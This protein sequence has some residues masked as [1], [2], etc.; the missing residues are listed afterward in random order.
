LFVDLGKVSCNHG[1]SCGYDAAAFTVGA[2]TTP[3]VNSNSSVKLNENLIRVGL[4][5][6][7]G[8]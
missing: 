1:Y 2:T 6:K 5:F 3:A 4:N 8:H 7:W